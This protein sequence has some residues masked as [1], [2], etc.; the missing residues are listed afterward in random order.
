[1][2]LEEE[3]SSK[4]CYAFA[5]ENPKDWSLIYWHNHHMANLYPKGM[6][7]GFRILLRCFGTEL[8]VFPLYHMR[9]VVAS[10][11]LKMIFPA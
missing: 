8:F 9:A 5:V 7:L 4:E 2:Q 3:L 1:M 11:R 6:V 10:K